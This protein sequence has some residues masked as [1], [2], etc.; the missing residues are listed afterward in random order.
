MKDAPQKDLNMVS[1]RLVESFCYPHPVTERTVLETHISWVVLTGD[2]AYKI[3]KPVNFGFVDYTTLQRRK[4]FCER[5][6]ELN[7]RFAADLYLGVVPVI[8]SGDRTLIGDFS[9]DEVEGEIIDYAVKMKQFPQSAIVAS[10]LDDPGLTKKSFEQFARYLADFHGRIE[11]VIPTQSFVQTQQILDDAADNFHVLLDPLS[12]NP[13]F[14]T[15]KRLEKWTSTKGNQLREKFERR[16]HD[17]KVKRCHGD[18]HL[19]NIIQ[20]DG[21]LLAFDG[22][23]FNEQFQCVDV[24]SEVAFPVMDLF[25]RDRRDL[26]WR[27]LNAYL[28]ATGEYAD[29]DVLLYYLVY[30]AMV[31]AKV[32]WLNPGNH[33]ESRRQ[34]YAPA[35]NPDDPCAGPWDKYLAVANYLATE[36]SPRLAITHGFSGS[37]KSTVALEVIDNEGG[38]RIRSDVL[39]NKFAAQFKV[40]DKYSA[41]MSNWIY[42][43]LVE[44][45]RDAIAARLPVIIDATF[46]KADRRRPFREL[47]LEQNVPFEIIHCEADFNELCSRLRSRK[48]DPS[49]ADVNVL[50]KQLQLHDPLTVEEL[51]FVR[52]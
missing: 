18:L 17:G 13:R 30:R 2:Y 6:V 21:Q 9:L 19:K 16:L 33:S 8:R 20:L 29:L 44:F 43:S 24:L 31:R 10:R 26:A 27:L 52:P 3:K 37:G 34:E 51:T 15:L 36:L 35:S 22:I 1:G 39:R 41:E 46:L 5:E 4:Q 50:R 48:N 38:I 42:T 40:Q 7:R 14:E 32:A 23:E 25:A 49:E 47:A 28:E 12:E 11:S 45:A